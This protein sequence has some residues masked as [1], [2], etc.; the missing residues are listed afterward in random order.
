MKGSWNFASV[1]SANQM[2]KLS[3]VGMKTST[4][5]KGP[6]LETSKFSLY[7]FRYALML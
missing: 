2:N 1:G 4:L 5:D 3:L 7:I 6:S